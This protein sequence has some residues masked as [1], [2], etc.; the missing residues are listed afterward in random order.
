[1]HQVVARFAE[2]EVAVEALSSCQE[3]ELSGGFRAT[4]PECKTGFRA[5]IRPEPLHP[6]TNMRTS[7]SRF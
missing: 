3:A 7:E 1:M 4:G 6:E 2:E 5:L